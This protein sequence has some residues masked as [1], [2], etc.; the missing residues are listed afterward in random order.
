LNITRIPIRGFFSACSGKT[1][2][3]FSCRPGTLGYL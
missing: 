3:R 2:V 1:A